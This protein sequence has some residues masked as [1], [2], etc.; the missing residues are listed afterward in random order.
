MAARPSQTRFLEVQHSPAVRGG[1]RFDIDN[2]I[3][4]VLDVAVAAGVIGDD[5]LVHELVAR[6]G[7]DDE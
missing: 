3:K 6:F 4:A 2:A 5:R 1:Q 7:G